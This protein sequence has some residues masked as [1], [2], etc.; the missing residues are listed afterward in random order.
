MVDFVIV[1]GCQ[2]VLEGGSLE[3]YTPRTH[4]YSRL[5]KTIDIYNNLDSE[6]KYIICSGSFGEAGE[7]KTFLMRYGISKKNILKEPD[8]KNTIENC[9]FSYLLISKWLNNRIQNEINIHLITN[10]Y[11]IKRAEIIFKFFLKRLPPRFINLYFYSSNVLSYLDNLTEKDVEE[12]GENH[13]KEENIIKNL[14][15]Q[16]SQY[17]NW[18]PNQNKSKF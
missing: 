6:E 14:K 2:N 8:S 16:L 13:A 9:I 17:E 5:T 1:L 12:I 18:Y 11:H 15:K 3:E 7:M 4:I 10:D